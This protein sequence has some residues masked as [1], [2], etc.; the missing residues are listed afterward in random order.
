MREARR[1]KDGGV[2]S[3]EE[4]EGSGRIVERAWCGVEAEMWCQ[5]R[6]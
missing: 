4:G 2:K 5:V 6:E 3:G 1:P